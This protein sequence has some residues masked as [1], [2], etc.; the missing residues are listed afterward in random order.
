MNGHELKIAIPGKCL[1]PR[2]SVWPI[3]YKPDDIRD[4]WAE[5]GRTSFLSESWSSYN[6]NTPKELILPAIRGEP[7]EEDKQDQNS[8]QLVISNASVNRLM[9]K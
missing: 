7:R 8:Q 9:C 4:H 3:K 5:A 1:E 6:R 2:Y